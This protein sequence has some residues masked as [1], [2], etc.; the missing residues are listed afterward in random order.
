MGL[1]KSVKG[2]KEC[3]QFRQ[4]MLFPKISCFLLEIY[5]DSANYYDLDGLKTSITFRF[6]T[7]AYF[8]K[9][10]KTRYL[11]NETQT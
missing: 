1:L 10:L 5:L 8:Y 9:H 11:L 7:I 4:K 2:V 6:R 3:L